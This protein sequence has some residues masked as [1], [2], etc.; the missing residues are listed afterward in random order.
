MTRITLRPE[1][2]TCSSAVRVEAADVRVDRV[3][4]RVDQ[5]DGK[6]CFLSGDGILLA[7]SVCHNAGGGEGVGVWIESPPGSPAG[8]LLTNVTAI[9]DGVPPPSNDGS[10][11]GAAASGGPLQVDVFNVIAQSSGPIDIAAS[12]PKRAATMLRPTPRGSSLR[13]P[14]SRRR[15]S[16]KRS[17]W[18]SV[19][20]RPTNR[21][22]W[23]A[24]S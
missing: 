22:R 11:I 13:V 10:A 12:G 6:G 18:R 4:A 9:T 20:V 24:P 21:R 14:C 17:S 23:L 1:A 15:A 8:V 16:A 3:V 7:N 2:T 19:S 5:G